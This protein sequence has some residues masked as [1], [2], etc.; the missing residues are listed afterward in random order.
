MLRLISTFI[1]ALVLSTSNAV[2]DEGLG[3]YP[4]KPITFVVSFGPGGGTDI[5]ARLI[6]AE[7]GERIGQPVVVE[8][9]PGASGIL[10]AQY[11]ARSKADGYTL[12]IGGSGPM[13]FNTLIYN[14]LPYDPFEDF[15]AVTILGSY[16]IVLVAN[17]DQPFD[18]LE[19][20][21]TYA[22]EN[23]GELNYGS[24]GASFQVPTEY[25]ASEA[26]IEMTLIPYK[27]TAEASQALMAGEL[28]LVSADLGPVAS[29]L[30]SGK[31]KGLAVTTKE[32]NPILPDVPSVTEFGFDDFD[33]S[34]YSA[35]AA[36]KGTP[37]A[38][39][40]YLQRELHEVLHSDK[41]VAQLEKLG[42]TPEGMPTE[43]A[44]ERYRY[45]ADLFRPI[46]EEMGLQVD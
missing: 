27:G 34:L 20:M 4:D 43:E 28:Q 41:V 39:T 1:M 12:L 46:V 14:S 30:N 8:N 18:T 7:L 44:L 26:D 32:R 17:N 45:E 22:K 6:A 42:I 31:V 13:V 38:I 29:L 35:V 11:V 10:A 9:K 24:A 36:P 37:E 16:P 25:F 2:A 5:V 33:V 40:Q 15:E 21:I 19:E 3:N 23:P